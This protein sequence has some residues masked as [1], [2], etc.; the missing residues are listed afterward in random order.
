MELLCVVLWRLWY[1]RNQ[2]VHGKAHNGQEDMVSW[3]ASFLR[4]FKGANEVTYV[5]RGVVAEKWTRWVP[6]DHNLYKLNCDV[7]LDSIHVGL[8]M[9]IRDSLGEVLVTSAQ[10][11]VSNVSPQ[12]A[13]A[14]AIFKGLQFAMNNGLLP[15]VIEL[16][17]QGV[18]NYINND[19]DSAAEL[20][21]IIWDIK[22]LLQMSSS[23]VVVYASRKANMVAHNLS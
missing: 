12:I 16:D 11:L 1:V 13:K 14:M 18:V 10:R 17:A 6:P 15:V 21:L 5:N 2:I 22:D 7:A 19:L 3:C 4:D 8:G 20:G 9:V 23:I